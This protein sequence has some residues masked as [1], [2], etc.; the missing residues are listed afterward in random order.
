[1]GIA[2]AP[3][4]SVE[5][6][7]SGASPATTSVPDEHVITILIERDVDMPD[8]A[9]V[10]L[11]NANDL[12]TRTGLATTITIRAGDGAD[13][14]V[15][16]SGEI[17]SLEPTYRGG[18][19]TR[20]VVRAMNRM[21]RMLRKRRS[22]T[23]TDK[24]DR[25]IVAQLAKDAG[26][27][28]AW[29]HDTTLTH[30]HV[31]QHAQSDLDFV[32]E[33]AARL[34]CHVWCI[35][36][37]LHVEQPTFSD[38]LPIKLSVDEASANAQLRSFAPRMSAATVVHKVTVRGWNPET[39]ELITGEATASRS[40]LGTTTAVAAAGAAGSEDTVTVDQPI[41]SREEATALARARLQQALLGFIT[42]DA[43]LTGNPHVDLAK[44]VS[45]TANAADKQD[46]FNG[47]Y[48]IHGVTHR[49]AGG[50]YTTALRLWRDAQGAAS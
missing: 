45:I 17:I 24:T 37:T 1:M 28:L 13:R 20:V 12:Y 11:S 5:L 6:A 15:I 14:T 31:Y 33:R 42:G 9:A 49:V 41:W 27:D 40:P 23:Y 7:G 16:F 38:E 29:R 22:L 50:S 32:R 2:A 4:V 48:Y 8:T 10:T 3:H 44:V 47:K 30:A 21:H 34:G 36:T 25:D 19:G 43:E 26:L 18:A 35:G 46:P 39:K